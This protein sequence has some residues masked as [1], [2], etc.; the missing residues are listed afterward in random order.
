MR[1]GDAPAKLSMLPVRC[2]L[3]CPYP[4]RS[5]EMTLM[6]CSAKTAAFRNPLCNRLL[7]GLHRIDPE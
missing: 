1:S 3:L 6:L 2:G 7:D 5:T 4:G